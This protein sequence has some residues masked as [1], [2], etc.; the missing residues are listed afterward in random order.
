LAGFTGTER[1]TILKRLGSGGFGVVYEAFDH[2]RQRKV[3]LK[4]PHEANAFNIYMVKQEFRAL[5]DVT[6]P[7]LVSL[8]E[9]L[10]QGPDWFFTMELVEGPDFHRRLRPE[11]RGG[12]AG[13][14]GGTS[15]WQ[16]RDPATPDLD[17]DATRVRPHY[18][19]WGPG[20]ATQG[21]ST[22]S[23][24][25]DTPSSGDGGHSFHHSPPRDYQ[26]VRD[27]TRQLAEGRGGLRALY[28]AG[29]VPVSS[30]KP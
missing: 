15:S 29:L 9:L 1:F 4:V 5:A 26:E 20:R 7:N 6:H 21:I 24:N 27:L 13:G 23:R 14:D 18:P 30:A 8:Y 11:G 28:L 17:P 2:E 10:A 12:K 3:A 22:E 25:S 19:F 16:E